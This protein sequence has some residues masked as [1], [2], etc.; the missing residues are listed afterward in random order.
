MKLLKSSA[1]KNLAKS[2]SASHFIFCG[3]SNQIVHPNFFSWSKVKTLLLENNAGHE[4]IQILHTNYRNSY[5]ITEIANRILKIK[6]QR[7]G[8]ID[9]ESNYLVTTQSQNSGEI[10]A[11]SYQEKI[12]KELNQL[13]KRSTKFAI[14]V[15]K[16]D[17]GQIAA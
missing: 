10:Y 16:L 8:S 1:G 12:I 13:S 15:M 9:K 3:D 2:K 14:L 5:A 4:A 11:L 6:Q 7:F 17:F